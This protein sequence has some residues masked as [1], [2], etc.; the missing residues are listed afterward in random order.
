MSLT[1]ERPINFNALTPFELIAGGGGYNLITRVG[2]AGTPTNLERLK[3]LRTAQTHRY[4]INEDFFVPVGVINRVLG[5]N[6][7]MAERR[8]VPR[9]EGITAFGLF[10]KNSLNL[11]IDERSD[12]PLHRG[13][14]PSFGLLDF[15]PDKDIEDKKLHFVLKNDDPL[16]LPTPEDYGM[17]Q[18]REGTEELLERSYVKEVQEVVVGPTQYAMHEGIAFYIPN[19][20]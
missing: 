8:R 11:Y 17:L 19:D 6:E 2:E 16:R 12:P 9:L 18:L 1:S 5:I 7:I 15:N 14:F 10:N 3:D 4:Y 13:F 20:I